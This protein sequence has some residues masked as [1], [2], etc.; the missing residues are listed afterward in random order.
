M[1][2]ERKIEGGIILIDKPL[3]WTSFDVVAKLRNVLHY[4]K[5]GHAGTL[6]PLA[7]GLL[8]VCFGRFTKR[9]EEIQLLKKTYIAEIKLGETTPSFDLETEVD[10]VYETAHITEKLFN[11][12]LAEFRGTIQQLPPKF[13]AVKVNGVRAYKYARKGEEV[14]LKYR[15]VH[16]D[17]ISV[18][19]YSLPKVTLK[20]VCSKGTYIRSLARDIGATLNSGAHLTKLERTAIGDFHVKNAREPKSFTSEEDFYLH[21]ILEI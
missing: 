5:I 19:D 10:G 18:L 12:K 13:S 16:I 6:D 4:K 11:E 8:I 9:I 17:E 3:N 7:S 14:E 2:D 20:V 1:I 15:E 21:R